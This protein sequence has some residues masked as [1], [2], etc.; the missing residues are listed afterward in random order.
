MPW[1]GLGV[2]RLTPG[3]LRRNCMYGF[4]VRSHVFFMIQSK[5]SYTY[6]L[7]E[8]LICNEKSIRFG[9]VSSMPPSRNSQIR[10]DLSRSRNNW[11]S[12]LNPRWMP[13]EWRV[14]TTKQTSSRLMR[15]SLAF[16][17]HKWLA[18][19]WGWGWGDQKPD[20]FIWQITEVSSFIDTMDLDF[21]RVFGQ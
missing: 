11:L 13:M 9:S 8:L 7:N 12:I 16:A 5:N 17:I 3:N 20:G 10:P 15:Q 19:G 21:F 2:D 4:I 1:H 6:W 18:L 14:H